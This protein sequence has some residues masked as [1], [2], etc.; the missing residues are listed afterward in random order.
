MPTCGRI[1]RIISEI[2]E[3][4][5]IVIDKRTGQYV[6]AHDLRR[7]FATRWAPRVKPV[8]LQRLMRHKSIGTTLKYYVDQDADEIADELW[9]N[10]GVINTFI[11]SRSSEGPDE[12]KPAAS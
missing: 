11:N 10:H 8:T 1:G 3:T 4:A 2:G 7:S 9:R 12:P 6:T 5:G